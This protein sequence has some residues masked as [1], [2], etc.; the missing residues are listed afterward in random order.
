MSDIRYD[1]APNALACYLQEVSRHPLLDAD[2]EIRLTQLASQGDRAARQRMIESNLR[3]VIHVAGRYWRSALDMADLI[4]EGNLG[5]I[6]ALDKFD[7]G[8][9]Y[10]FSTYAMWWIKQYIERGIMNQTR[11]VRLPI[12]QAKR[13][14]HL[15]RCRRQLAQHTYREPSLRDLSTASGLAQHEVRELLPWH[16][17]SCSLNSHDGDGESWLNNLA[18]P[19]QGDPAAAVGNSD[20]Q[21]ALHRFIHRLKPREQEILKLRF[22][23]TEAGEMTLEKIAARVGITRERVRQILMDVLT[24]LGLWMA[25]ENLLV[26]CLSDPGIS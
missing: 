6:H 1:E 25:S 7:P 14:N 12:H 23:F 13:L 15:L 4:E 18:D 17:A 8:L 2:E 5:L 9:G 26:D 22:G 21:Q 3:L 16:E 20:L 24:R 19:N 11:P 10:R